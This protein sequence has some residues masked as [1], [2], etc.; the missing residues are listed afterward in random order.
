MMAVWL[1]IVDKQMQ[2]HCFNISNI[3][4]DTHTLTL[5]LLGDIGNDNQNR[6]MPTGALKLTKYAINYYITTNVPKPNAAGGGGGAAANKQTN[7]KRCCACP[8]I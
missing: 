7:E 3:Q 2:V 6:Q 8:A 4:T 5:V 1:R